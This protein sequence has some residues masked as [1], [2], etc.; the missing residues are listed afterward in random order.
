M[1]TWVTEDLE[2]RGIRSFATKLDGAL[3]RLLGAIDASA[4][5]TCEA[6]VGLAEEAIPRALAAGVEVCLGPYAYDCVE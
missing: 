6:T 2:Q 3:A 1:Q 5:P 4:M